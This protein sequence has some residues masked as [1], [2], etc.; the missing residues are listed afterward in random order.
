MT[1]HF[2]ISVFGIALLA[3]LPASSQEVL[4]QD[5]VQRY[6][7]LDFEGAHLTPAGRQAIRDL[8]AS[9]GPSTPSRVMVQQPFS[10][11]HH[12]PTNDGK[13][14]YRID[15]QPLGTIDVKQAQ[16]SPYPPRFNMRFDLLLV[17]VPAPKPSGSVGDDATVWRIQGP[18][19]NPNMSV[20]S[21]IRY[22]EQL[23]DDS[24]DAAIRKN[25]D[26]TLVT[27]KRL[28]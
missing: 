21:A 1:S 14:W 2:A 19:P 15:H 28:R 10:A 12:I 26:R 20:E 18:I 8:F 27:L 24:K 23:R 5:L 22:V 11:A 25:A 6:A 7:T 16:F 3:G 13:V 4:Q 17:K 9:P